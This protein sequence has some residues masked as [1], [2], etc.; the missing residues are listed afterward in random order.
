MSADDE[1]RLLGFVLAAYD[2][3]GRARLDFVTDR[4]RL[5]AEHFSPGPARAAF[6]AMQKVR[7]RHSPITLAAVVA[8]LQLDPE[9]WHVADRMRLSARTPW[10]GVSCDLDEALDIARALVA[11]A[12][13]EPPAAA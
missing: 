13:P 3:N 9:W 1:E 12:T 11:A 5:D 4:A 8:Q 6:A 7:A 10:P 2:G